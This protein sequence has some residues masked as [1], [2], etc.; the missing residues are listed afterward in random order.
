MLYFASDHGGFNLKAALL[1]VVKR[2]KIAHE[3]LGATA[4]RPSDD[5]TTYARK[6]AERMRGHPRDRAVLICGSGQGMAIAANRYRHLRVAHAV[7]PWYAKRARIDE[8]VNVLA[9]SGWQTSPAEAARIVRTFLQTP[10]SRATRY[11]RRTRLLRRLG[12]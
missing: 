5:Y 1:R 10:K 4:Y 3:D 9:L 2:W 11:V 7:T 12:P 6:V 8:D